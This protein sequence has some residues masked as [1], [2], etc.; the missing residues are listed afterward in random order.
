MPS[1]DRSWRLLEPACFLFTALAASWA[2]AQGVQGTVF[3]VIDPAAPRAEWR[4]V[5]SENAFVIVHWTGHIP[6]FGHGEAVCL[7][8]AIAKTDERGRF[9]ISEPR[10]LRSTFMVFRDDPA[11]AVYKPGFDT[12]PDLRV[13][14]P[15]PE[16]LLVRTKLTREQRAGLAEMLS[17][18]G[19]RDDNGMLVLLTDPQGVLPAFRSAIR[20]ESGAKPP[21]PM[22]LRVL[23]RSGPLPA[24]PPSGRN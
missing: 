23:P 19:C 14:G 8:A 4:R 9:G 15:R 11:V 18:M 16:W 5:P 22:K 10:P 21:P 7:Q 3:E 12:P 24:A 20:E 2:S 1:S 17:D 6:R 13:R